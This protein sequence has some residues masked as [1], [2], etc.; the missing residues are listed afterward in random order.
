VL[1]QHSSRLKKQLGGDR[2]DKANAQRIRW[3]PPALEKNRLSAI[4]LRGYET[5]LF[6][7]FFVTV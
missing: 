2:V 7:G 6:Q 4:A 3:T 5:K 1:L